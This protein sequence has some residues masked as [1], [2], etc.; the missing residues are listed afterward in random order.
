MSMSFYDALQ[1][2]PAAL[3]ARIRAS[4]SQREK[5]FFRLALL[6]RAL[7][8]VGF[9]ILFIGA[10][11]SLFGAE[12]SPMAVVLFCMLLSIRFVNF[13]YCIRDSL[14]AL[15]ASLAVLLLAPGLA[16][17]APAALVAPIHLAAA[18]SLLFM[19]AQQP[20]LGNGGLYS[21]AYIYLVGNPV[22]GEALIRRVLL[23]LTGCIICAAV[24]ILKH[25]SAHSAIRFH[26]IL[27]NFSLSNAAHL[28]QLRMAL[29]ISLILTLGRVLQ[30]ERFMWMGFA[31]TSIL[32][33]YPYSGRVTPR[34]LQRFSAC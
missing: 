18:F 20:E 30:I 34:F 26:H 23:T 12:N 2:D 22:F 3:K 14:L 16:A 31:C 19:T 6:S 33:A 5:N 13:S 25:R 21:F 4:E 9:A 7:L 17:R 28:W 10:G 15:A 1:L 11:T 32:S 24:L 29:A 27:R 8:L